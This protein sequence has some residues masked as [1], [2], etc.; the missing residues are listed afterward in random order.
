MLD[1]VSSMKNVI[2]STVALLVLLGAVVAGVVLVQQEQDI[3]NKAASGS[4]CQH[5]SDC[6]LLDNPGNVGTYSAPGN[7]RYVDITD[8]D[9]HRYN[10]G[11]SDDCRRVSINGNTLS[12]ERIG[13]G[14]E[15]KDVSN[16]QVWFDVNSQPS[17]SPT[18]SPSSSP[19]ASASPTSSASSSPSS[20]ASPTGSPIS[21]MG[22]PL[23]P[24]VGQILVNFNSARI[25]SDIN[26]N[27][28]TS[29]A[30]PFSVN[31][32]AGN[33][34]V[35]LSSSDDHNNLNEQQAREQYY[36]KILS[37]SQSLIASTNPIADLPT[38]EHTKTQVVN[39]NLTISQNATSVEVQHAAFYDGTS[40]Q[41]IR[42]ECAIFERVIVTTNAQCYEVKVFDDNWAKI[43]PEDYEDLTEGETIRFTVSGSTD[44]G[45]FDKARFL[46][47]GAITSEVTQKRPGTNEFYI[48]YV[49]PADMSQLSV[50]G[51]LHHTTLGWF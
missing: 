39:E 32:P 51:E 29:K 42:A 12:W 35:I 3:R 31:L 14:P 26:T 25:R 5:A 18:A 33:Y 44:Q 23:V 7:I 43:L 11:D 27:P 6:D 30:G 45:S 15:C 20:S 28:S 4:D 2:L 19:T 21:S 37:S 48:E 50:K 40:P 16:V 41:S 49:I 47:N 10:P 38:N 36:L 17:P 9:Y 22:C 46:V 1:T 8:Q 34:K 24:T 13:D